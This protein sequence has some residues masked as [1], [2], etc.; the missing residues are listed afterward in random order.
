MCR[1]LHSHQLGDVPGH[2][3]IE[4]DRC[5]VWLVTAFPRCSLLYDIARLLTRRRRSAFVVD[6]TISKVANHQLIAALL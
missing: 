5:D 6:H 3:H 4:H 1:E 2:T